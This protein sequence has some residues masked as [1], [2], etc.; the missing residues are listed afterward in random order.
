LYLSDT[1]T[2]FTTGNNITLN[3]P[4]GSSLTIYGKGA[5][6]FDNNAVINN[7]AADPSKFLVYSTSTQPVTIEN[8]GAFYGAIYAPSAAVEISNNAGF[9]GAVVGN[10][11]DQLNNGGIHYDENLLNLANPFGGTVL[12]NW[13]EI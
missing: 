4:S 11:I 9:Y 10:T 6:T 5:M 7:N 12:S 13:Q 8:N 3:V 2:S 1:T